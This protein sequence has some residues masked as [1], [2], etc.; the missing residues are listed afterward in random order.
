MLYVV[1][2]MLSCRIWCI[3][4]TLSIVELD[5]KCLQP[6][7]MID[8]SNSPWRR[9]R[10]FGETS[11]RGFFVWKWKMVDELIDAWMNIHR[12]KI[13][14]NHRWDSTSCHPSIP[15]MPNAPLR[16]QLFGKNAVSGIFPGKRMGRRR[17][18]GN[19]CMKM[20]RERTELCFDKL[21]IYFPACEWMGVVGFLKHGNKI[22]VIFHTPS[23]PVVNTYPY[24]MDIC[25]WMQSPP[26]SRISVSKS[27]PPQNNA[28]RPLHISSLVRYNR[29]SMKYSIHATSTHSNSPWT[30]IPPITIYNP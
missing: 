30:K 1:Y 6:E 2:C 29:I 27:V 16:Y 23:I 21:K 20:D 12:L 15:D 25:P 10:F 19:L 7:S 28:Y 8:M 24:S 22:K 4:Y 13:E 18:R 14:S 5:V 3:Q 9:A 11:L 17:Y 26:S